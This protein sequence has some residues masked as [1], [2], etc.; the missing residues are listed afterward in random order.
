MFNFAT[1]INFH[2]VHSLWLWKIDADRFR[3]TGR[4]EDL[5]AS[6]RRRSSHAVDDNGASRIG[7]GGRCLIKTLL[8]HA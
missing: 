1:S 3:T 4:T 7:D 8:S 6:K 5:F 2:V